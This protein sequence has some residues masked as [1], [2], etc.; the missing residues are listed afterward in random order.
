MACSTSSAITAAR[1]ESCTTEDGTEYNTMGK[2]I[3][4]SLC[5]Q[6]TKFTSEQMV[7]Q[8][9]SISDQGEMT[10][11]LRLLGSDCNLWANG[12]DQPAFVFRWLSE[13]GGTNSGNDD[14]MGRVLE[15]FDEDAPE[16][17]EYLWAT[18]YTLEHK[19]DAE[20]QQDLNAAVSST[21][22]PLPED[23][24]ANDDG[25][26]DQRD[27]A[28]VAPMHSKQV[29]LLQLEASKRG[30]KA[31]PIQR[32]S[33]AAIRRM[34]STQQHL[35]AI[36]WRYMWAEHDHSSDSELTAILAAVAP[37]SMPMFIRMLATPKPQCLKDA[38]IQA[39]Q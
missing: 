15:W 25:E 28:K 12:V 1:K 38:L 8:L 21:A 22:W 27:D 35:P 39:N 4:W 13:N 2:R 31:R 10:E 33:V 37:A 11:L 9:R 30:I 29:Q 20:I 26:E 16:W 19:T 23:A 36:A 6:G 18:G 3:V 24:L 32:R 7:S 5:G 17:F 14:M 34:H